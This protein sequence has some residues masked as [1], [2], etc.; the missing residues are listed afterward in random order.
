MTIE[1][2]SF[3]K[4]LIS[5]SSKLN[6]EI[7]LKSFTLREIAVSSKLVKEILLDSHVDMEETGI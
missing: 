3:I 2:Q 6:R 7:N 1:K 4:T 5:E